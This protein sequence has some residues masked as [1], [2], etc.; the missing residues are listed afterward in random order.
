MALTYLFDADGNDQK[1][2]LAA[3]NFGKLGA[4]Q[5]VW[6]DLV[7]EETAGMSNLPVD[8][9]EVRQRMV[10]DD[11]IVLWD[12]YYALRYPVALGR[13]DGNQT[14]LLVIGPSW[15][16]TIEPERP[17]LF[18]R[19][20]EHDSGK[21][22]KGN[23]SS[24]AFAASL[25]TRFFDDSHSQLA[26]IERHIDLLDEDILR[27]RERRAPLAKLAVLRTR[28]AILRQRH[29][30]QRQMVYRLGRPDFRTQIDQEDHTTL[31][32]LRISADRLDDEIARVRDAIVGSFDLYAARVGNDTNQL[33]K[34]L[35]VITVVTGIM[36]AVAGVFGMNFAT[37]LAQMGLTAFL[38]VVGSTMAFSIGVV[39]L[40]LFRKWV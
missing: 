30:R 2:E 16:I 8:L 26:A 21:T 35:T 17:K 13:E 29:G 33:L 11:E 24:T 1:V 5:L 22:L 7:D 23:L 36:G 15:L 40:A 14:M 25:L 10:D 28:L 38:V 4:S 18:D 39:A 6:L 27:S 9:A 20:I 12:D 19:F 32:E 31:T 34:T 37:P 3:V